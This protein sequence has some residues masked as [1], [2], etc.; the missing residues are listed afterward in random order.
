MTVPLEGPAK[1]LYIEVPGDA[2]LHNLALLHTGPVPEEIPP[3][4][5]VVLDGRQASQLPLEGGAPGGELRSGNL[6]DGCVELAPEN[7]AEQ[8]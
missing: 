6:G 3:A 1:A 4:H 5:R 8:L 2:A 7:T